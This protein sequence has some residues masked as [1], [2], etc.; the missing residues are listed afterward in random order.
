MPAPNP[1]LAPVTRPARLALIVAFAA[2]TAGSGGGCA[3]AQTSCR[4]AAFPAVTP[5]RAV[6][7]ADGAGNFQGASRMLHSVATADRLPIDVRTYDW[8]HGYGRILADQL[9]YGDAREEGRHLAGAVLDY[10]RAHPDIPIYLTG[11]SAGAGVV[12]AAL[13]ALP[14]G[15]VERAILLSPS[16]S[17]YYDLRPALCRVNRSLHVFYSERDCWYLGVYT[18]LV[19]TADRRWTA[20]SGRVGFHVCPEELGPELLGKLY[21]RSWHPADQ[22]LG[23]LGGHYGNYQPNFLRA[24]VLPL[25]FA[26]PAPLDGITES[27]F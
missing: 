8:S 20:T 18:R 3:L 14:P 25:I 4:P 2:L 11:H 5:T 23:N 15:V 21:Q 1:P 24:H 27:E 22:Q 6:F 10:R 12:L 17:T 16:V 7:V 9:L 13:E 26:E 19:G